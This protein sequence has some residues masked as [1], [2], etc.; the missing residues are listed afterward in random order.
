MASQ[1]DNKAEAAPTTAVDGA[2]DAAAPEP[3]AETAP[4]V[5]E[6]SA[7]ERVTSAEQSKERGNELLKV[8][9][10]LGAFLKYDDGIRMVEPLL[11]KDQTEV[12]V[13]LQ[14]R[15]SAVYLALRLNSAQAC[16]KKGDLEG[17]IN[18]S[19]KA[20]LID[21]ENSKALYRRAMAC[22]QIGTLGRLEQARTDLTRFVQ[23]EPS[24]RDA[25]D[26]LA[27]TKERLKVEKQQ[28][29]DR[30]ASALKGGGLYEE[31]HRKQNMLQSVYEEEAAR[32][33]AAGEPELTFEEW[34]KKRKDEAEEQKKKDMALAEERSKEL[35][36]R[37]HEAELAEENTRRTAEGLEELTLEAFL[38]MRRNAPRKV[39]VVKTDDLE[40][41]EEEKK[42][43]SEAKQKGYYHGRLGTVL[44]NDAPKPQQVI[45]SEG[46]AVVNATGDKATKRRSEWN[47]AGTWEETDMTSWAKDELKQWI[48]KASATCPKV[49]TVSGKAYSLAVRV[50]TVKS[51]NGDAQLVVVRNK[52]R[53]GFNF[54]AEASFHLTFTPLEEDSLVEA[55]GQPTDEFKGRL[56]MPDISDMADLNELRIDWSWKGSA[57]PQNL[58]HSANI[59]VEHFRENIRTQIAHFVEE[60]KKK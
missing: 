7:E 47:E 12:G 1:E 54:D 24:N 16:L 59:W 37:M 15:A 33:Q 50:S 13:E 41:D 53:H 18:H 44:S 3:A 2:N 38:E 10:L 60:Y 31:I 5:P 57:P 14:Q 51:V 35:Q 40:L 8:G 45:K 56:Q 6:I 34:E 29:K 4:A 28:E 52:T 55:S 58:S 43:L 32:R 26:Q 11:E 39:E 21:S 20:L 17:A 25:R 49:D 9:Q 36:K 42:L 22:M 27:K 19:S 46:D 48:K 23:L 30:Y